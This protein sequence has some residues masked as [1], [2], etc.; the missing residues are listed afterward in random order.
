MK[1]LTMHFS[2][3]SCY[4]LTFRPQGYSLAPKVPNTLNLVLPLMSDTKFHTH[5]N[6]QTILYF[7]TL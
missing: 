6:Q 5:T 7:R 4:V 1:L 3:V 2:L